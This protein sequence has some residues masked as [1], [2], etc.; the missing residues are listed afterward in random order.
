MFLERGFI[1]S[2]GRDVACNVRTEVRSVLATH[3]PGK[4]EVSF[5]VGD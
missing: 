4:S 2:E 1:N 5:L 3:D